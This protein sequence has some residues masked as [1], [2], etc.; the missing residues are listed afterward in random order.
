MVMNGAARDLLLEQ[1]DLSGIIY[2][3]WWFYLLVSAFGT[4]LYD[5]H[6]AVEYRRHGGNAV[7]SPIGWRRVR[8]GWRV[9][10]AGMLTTRM[11]GQALALEREF[12]QRLP[13]SSREILREFLQ[14]PTS[15]HERVRRVFSR[16][17]YRQRRLDGAVVR[18]LLFLAKDY[19]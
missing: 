12:G 15:P 2:P 1:K 14:R 13:E 3:D 11:R 6:M 17:I 16:G 19:Q 10:T 18:T 5:S 7:G 4:V 9:V 8:E